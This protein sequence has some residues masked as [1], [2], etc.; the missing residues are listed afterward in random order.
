MILMR[1]LGSSR[2]DHSTKI[3]YLSRDFIIHPIFVKSFREYSCI[4][5]YRNEKEEAA[6]QSKIILL[7]ISIEITVYA[8]LT[9][10]RY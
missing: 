1:Q 10:V 3:L 4:I 2:Y 8:F 5:V 7:K 9:M 6:G